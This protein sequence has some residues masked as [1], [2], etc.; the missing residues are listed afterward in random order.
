MVLYTLDVDKGDLDRIQSQGFV[1][2]K[3]VVRSE[4][5][6]KFKMCVMSCGM[7]LLSSQRYY[8]PIW[9]NT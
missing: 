4:E 2:K 5:M 9:Y 7:L 6:S 8:L 3:R 1:P